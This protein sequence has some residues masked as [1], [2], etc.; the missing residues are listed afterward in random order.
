ME[1]IL[2]ILILLSTN[3]F[4]IEWIEVK[5]PT[6]T[7]NEKFEIELR[8]SYPYIRDFKKGEWER[9]K[10]PKEF[11][12]FKFNSVDADNRYIMLVAQNG[13]VIKTKHGR[14]NHKRMKW[15]GVWGAPFGKGS[16]LVLPQTADYWSIQDWDMFKDKYIVNPINNEKYRTLSI[17]HIFQIHKGRSRVTVHDPWL[18]ADDYGYEIC[19][20]NHGN[21]KAVNFKSSGAFVFMLDSKGQLQTRLWNLDIAGYNHIYARYKYEVP[22][23]ED[24]YRTRTVQFLR[25][26][27]LPS[28]GWDIQPPIPGQFT[29]A[30]TIMARGR[31]SNQADLYV[32]GLKNNRRV[33]WY[34]GIHDPKWKYV[35]KGKK[36]RAPLFNSSIKQTPFIAGKN[37]FSKT[38]DISL[39]LLDYKDHCSPSVLRVSNGKASVDVKLHLRALYRLKQEPLPHKRRGAL[40]FP[41]K[42][43]LSKAQ[44]KLL[45]D[46]FGY[47]GDVF[48]NLEAM[49]DGKTLHIN[50]GLKNNILLK[51]E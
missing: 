42:A 34:K 32:E 16:K 26:I 50:E 14:K 8:N 33:I 11:R 21:S 28:P 17:A 22:V 2:Y 31:G 27:L 15:D 37:Y 3:L 13:L 38:D 1:K 46:F 35:H 12:G 45:T 19:L 25:R 5:T 9:L 44:S 24:R 39:R 20:P 51:S 36:L 49:Y 29:S 18:L 40:E 10:L 41:L 4:A 30:I 23:R 47:S 7:F 48:M 6:Y 43:R